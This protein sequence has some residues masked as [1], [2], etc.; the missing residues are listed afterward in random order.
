MPVLL[1]R[2]NKYH[3]QHSL[4]CDTNALIHTASFSRCFFQ[5]EFL[6][7]RSILHLG[8]LVVVVLPLGSGKEREKKEAF[9]FNGVES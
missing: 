3:K 8:S 9:N 5:S 6:Q 4:W 2:L 7:S 1:I